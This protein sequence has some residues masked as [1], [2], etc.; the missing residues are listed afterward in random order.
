MTQ[1]DGITSHLRELDE[2]AEDWKRYQSISLADLK[3]DRDKQH[4]VLH[5]LLVSIQASIDIANHLV[6]A[7]SARRPETYRESFAILCGEGLIQEDL[8]DQLSDLA[9]F[10]NVLVHVYWRLNLDEVYGVLQEDL[11]T[12]NRFRDLVR[13]MLRNRLSPE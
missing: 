6:A 10:R 3:A 12:V 2:A 5:A 11:P 1:Y 8:A 7:H 13:A 4:M 9:G